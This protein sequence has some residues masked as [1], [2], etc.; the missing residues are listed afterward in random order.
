MLRKVTGGLLTL[1]LVLTIIGP[2]G[3]LAQQD[4]EANIGSA[5]VAAETTIQQIDPPTEAEEPPA[6]EPIIEEPAIEP[7]AAEIPA[8]EPPPQVDTTDPVAEAPSVPVPDNGAGAPS[9]E[10]GEA[11]TG[12]EETAEPEMVAEGDEPVDAVAEEDSDEPEND[13]EWNPST[14]SNLSVTCDG[15]VSFTITEAH[16]ESLTIFLSDPNAPVGFSEL[17]SG[18]F[19]LSEIGSVAIPFE[20]ESRD[21]VRVEIYHSD[22][23][24]WSATIFNCETSEEETTGGV[25]NMTVDCFGQVSFEAPADIEGGFSIVLSGAND[26]AFEYI[27]GITLTPWFLDAG[28]YGHTFTIPES[29]YARLRAEVTSSRSFLPIGVAEVSGCLGDENPD[30]EPELESSVISDI[31]VSCDGLVTFTIVEAQLETLSIEL[32]IL[33]FPAN[34]GVSEF[35]VTGTGTFQVQV[36]VSGDPSDIRASVESP[37]ANESIAEAEV[38]DCRLPDPG[39]GDGVTNLAVSCD[40]VVSFTLTDILEAGAIRIF[41]P[42][43]NPQPVLASQVFPRFLY[44]GDYSYAL[45]IPDAQ[46]DQLLVRVQV[47]FYYGD[48]VA[49]ASVSGCLDDET[50]DPDPVV[51]EVQNLAVTCSGLVTFDLITSEPVVLDI[52]IFVPAAAPGYRDATQITAESGP[53]QV[54]FNLPVHPYAWATSVSLGTEWL[55]DATVQGCPM[56]P[57]NTLPGN[58]V[59]VPVAGGTV[60]FENVL[61][62]GQTF[63]TQLGPESA[64]PLPAEFAGQLVVIVDIATTAVIDGSAEVCLPIVGETAADAENVRLLHF[65]N[66]AWVDITTYASA[67]N[68]V[69]CGV[70]FNFS[71]FAIVR[72]ADNSPGHPAHPGN[73]EVPGN[74]GGSEQPGQHGKPALDHS[75]AS[76]GQAGANANLTT[77]PITGSG[78]QPVNSGTQTIQLLLSALALLAAGGLRFSTKR[79]RGTR[80]R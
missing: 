20:I 40:G 11:V 3:A 36:D 13:D 23:T 2:T 22:D 6:S 64:P 74:S 8:A 14:I 38:Y 31:T 1:M 21:S 76:G 46:Y 30:P 58:D 45:D 9:D 63:A 71:P 72:L 44:E 35:P 66:G 70:T 7:P 42:L 18:S 53:Q 24:Y 15:L 67:E 52:E 48:T 80:S 4:D 17:A 59:T 39:S 55:A 26:G 34:L 25:T 68:G 32:T 54:Q 41:D 16:S 69:V 51:P 73:P 79:M 61:E 78:A 10:I 57:L 28:S 27:D 56:Q 65:E 47:Q 29:T 19:D 5:P 33:N 50:P 62:P 12:D 75:S 60:T 77:L 49:W 37:G 43:Q